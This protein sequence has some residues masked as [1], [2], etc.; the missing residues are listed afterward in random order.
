[1]PRGRPLRVVYFQESRRRFNIRSQWWIITMLPS[2]TFEVIQ[3]LWTF[4]YFGNT[5]TMFW[6]EVHRYTVASPLVLRRWDTFVVI[7]VLWTSRQCNTIFC[8]KCYGNTLSNNDKSQ[9]LVQ[10]R[11]QSS[12]VDYLAQKWCVNYLLNWYI[13]MYMYSISFACASIFYFTCILIRLNE[14]SFNCVVICHALIQYTHLFL[15]AKYM[16]PS[17]ETIPLIQTTTPMWFW[18]WS[19][20]WVLSY[21]V[22]TTNMLR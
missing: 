17:R 8:V 20:S 3:L 10:C 15:N 18:G 5:T 19:Y 22:T 2:D 9:Q 21:T 16:N 7:Q 14:V 11:Q 13:Y 1:M 6:M 12:I 4:F